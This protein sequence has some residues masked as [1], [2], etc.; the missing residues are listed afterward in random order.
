MILHYYMKMCNLLKII[1]KMILFKI[2]ML[3]FES[4]LDAFFFCF[5]YFFILCSFILYYFFTEFIKIIKIHLNVFKIALDIYF[6]NLFL[7]L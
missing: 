2:K 4:L 5:F 7:F 6:G 1:L 3:L